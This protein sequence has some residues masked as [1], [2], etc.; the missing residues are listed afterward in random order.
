[1]ARSARMMA[2]LTAVALAA[3][4]LVACSS[5]GNPSAGPSTSTTPGVT[6]TITVFAASSLTDV[7]EEIATEFEAANPGSN[8]EFNFAASSQLATQVNEGAPADVLATASTGTMKTVTDAGNNEG[9]PVVFVKNQLVI[10]VEKGN[11][12]NIQSLQDLTKPGVTVVLCAE[13]VPC[14][15]AAKT[16]IQ[17]ANL[18]ITPVSFE[19]NVRDALGKVGEADAA[20]VYRTDAAIDDQVQAVEFAESASA[21]QSYPIATLKDAPNPE[22]AAA[23]VAWVLS[24]KGAAKLDAFGFQKP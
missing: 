8:V 14:G 7:F 15:A 9:D 12:K 17:S 16:A 5:D 19:Q 3:S 2:V 23:F 10:A 24:D 13:E 20:L 11:P 21:I 4:A 18:S 1:M 22:G 6:G